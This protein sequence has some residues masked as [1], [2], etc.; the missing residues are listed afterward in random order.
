MT[1]RQLLFRDDA[2]HR[3]LRGV[4]L[5]ADAVKETLGPRAHRAA[6]A[7]PWAADRD[8]L[9]GRGRA[10]DRARRSLREHGRPTGAEVA[11][12]TSEVAGD[13]TT[14]TT[15]LAAA[16]VREGMKH[17]AAGMNPMDL[18]RGVDRAVDALVGALKAMA[19]PCGTRT[20]IAQVA[21]ISANNDATIGE[22]IADAMERVG[23]D[24]VITVEEGSGLANRWTWSRACSSTVVTCRPIS[25]T[26]RVRASCSR[27][28]S[29]SC[30]TA[31][32]GAVAELLPVLEVIG[33]QRRPC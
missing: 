9:R 2:R 11:A 23:K 28:P 13:G 1:A 21:S 7:A 22:L 10:R 15:L 19:R 16:I 17:A 30:A 32:S 33:A 3:I 24:G 20:G 14:T 29:S 6:A 4:S 18:K 26:P 31:G 12:R 25:S 5:L 27:M 8:Q